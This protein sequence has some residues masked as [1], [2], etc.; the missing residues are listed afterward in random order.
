MPRQDAVLQVE[1]LGFAHPKQTTLLRLLATSTTDC[2]S[3]APVT[4]PLNSL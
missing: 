2:T 3:S 4:T 1:G